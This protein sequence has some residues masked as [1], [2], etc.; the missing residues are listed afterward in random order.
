MRTIP[1]V[2]FCDDIL[3]LSAVIAEPGENAG[4]KLFLPI[5]TPWQPQYRMISPSC[6]IFSQ[7]RATNRTQMLP[8]LS[9]DR[10][11]GAVRGRVLG[12]A[13]V[14]QGVLTSPAV[15]PERRTRPAASFHQ[16][17]DL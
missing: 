4:D 11:E 10:L 13:E 15:R 1:F 2:A 17:D 3:N 14:G 12:V 9:K 16:L 6:G 8:S 5:R 7:S